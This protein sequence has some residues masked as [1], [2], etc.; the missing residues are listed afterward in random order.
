MHSPCRHAPAHQPQCNPPGQP[1]AAAPPPS[2]QAA[3]HASFCSC[4]PQQ[5]LP[6]MQAAS[7]IHGILN[8]SYILRFLHPPGDHAAHQHGKHASATRAHPL[9]LFHVQLLHTH[10]ATMPLLTASS[11]MAAW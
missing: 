3:L 11:A 8:S 9:E 1:H 4:T 6:Q 10:P 5:N 2:P 7:V